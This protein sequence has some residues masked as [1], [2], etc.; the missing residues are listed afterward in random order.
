MAQKVHRSSISLEL[1]SPIISWID[2]S[3]SDTG[4][5]L[6][7]KMA[8]KITEDVTQPTN[9]LCDVKA[10]EPELKYG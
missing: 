3:V 4:V 5:R 2:Q 6:I 7:R 8:A 1:L 9:K 10:T